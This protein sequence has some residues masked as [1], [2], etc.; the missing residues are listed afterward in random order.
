VAHGAGAEQG[1]ASLV[2]QAR[3]RGILEIE[4][5][6]M[7]EEVEPG[8]VAAAHLEPVE[9]RQRDLHRSERLDRAG[10]EVRAT[11]IGDGA[12]RAQPVVAHRPYRVLEP[13]GGG[14]HVFELDGRQIGRVRVQ[15]RLHTVGRELQLLDVMLDAHEQGAVAEE[16]PHARRALQERVDVLDRGGDAREDGR[17][18]NWVGSAQGV[19]GLLELVEEAGSVG[20]HPAARP[21]QDGHDAAHKKPQVRAAA[22]CGS[23]TRAAG[24]GACDGDH[25]RPCVVHG[26]PGCESTRSATSRKGDG[27][28][29]NED[30]VRQAYEA[31]GKGDM[32]TLRSI[33][34][35][36]VT[37]S[38][39]GKSQIAG[40]HKGTDNVLGYYAQLFE[41]SGGTLSVQL[42]STKVEGDTVVSTHHATAQREG[43]SWDTKENI[44]F[45]FS[46][47]KIARLDEAPTD[48]AGLDAFW[49]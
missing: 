38:V 15:R 41:L 35:P 34:T 45:S 1:V 11:E 5:V 13:H 25:S 29:A 7:D 37:Q 39:P 49:S 27:V 48:L 16:G 33:M 22:G 47:D 4:P 3:E 24:A 23:A 44:T 32:D 9:R 26:V 40:D 17:A 12:R 18:R 14:V 21:P 19:D 10:R 46:G 30:R 28:S 8:G 31:F 42:E 20:R 2:Q 6:I 36:D 43:R